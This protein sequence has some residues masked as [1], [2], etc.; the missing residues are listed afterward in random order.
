L[1]I[2]G[3]KNH[4]G[5]LANIFR[6]LGFRLSGR[7][8]GKPVERWSQG[9]INLLINCSDEGFAQSHYVMH[10]SGV[11]AI[12]LRVDD[13]RRTMTRAKALDTTAFH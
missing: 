10:G 4:A 2:R 6:Q 7:H 12:A 9:A 13:V 5:D 8:R 3:D 1:S 11:C